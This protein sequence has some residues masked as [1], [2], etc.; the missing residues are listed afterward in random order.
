MMEVLGSNA[1]HV[2]DY[3]NLGCG[4]TQILHIV[5][6]VPTSIKPQHTLRGTHRLTFPT[7]H[8]THRSYI[9]DDLC[10]QPQTS[11]NKAV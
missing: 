11:T 7:H 4:F 3:R 5:A 1:S 10:I 6:E 2:K 9:L 8:T